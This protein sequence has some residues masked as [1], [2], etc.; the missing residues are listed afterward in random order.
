MH[1]CFPQT[2]ENHKKWMADLQAYLE[3]GK[4]IANPAP[5]PGRPGLSKPMKLI[6]FSPPYLFSQAHEGTDY[7]TTYRQ[8]VYEAYARKV[9]EGMG[10]PVADAGIITK[11]MWEAAYDGLHYLKGSSDN[12]YGSV[13]S[14]VFQAILNVIF[15]DCSSG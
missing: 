8:Q 10:I 4:V 12:W 3:N 6:W 9:V 13:S 14:M 5:V 1:R 11:A 15:P 7:V 2:F